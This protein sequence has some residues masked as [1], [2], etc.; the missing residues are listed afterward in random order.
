MNFEFV[1]HSW[2]YEH[3]GC[4]THTYLLTQGRKSALFVY[5]DVLID[6]HDFICP[7]FWQVLENTNEMWKLL[8]VMWQFHK[9]LDDRYISTFLPFFSCLLKEHLCKRS[10]L[11]HIFPLIIFSS[12][13]HLENTWRKNES[14]GPYLSLR[15]YLCWWLSSH[16]VKL[17]SQ[18]VTTGIVSNS[19]IFSILIP[20]VL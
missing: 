18:Y 8:L 19:F 7:T 9:W 14:N 15:I 4:D 2:S 16:L 17:Q 13:V 12:T 3:Y 1:I 11:N 5:L 10:V 6:R 20:L